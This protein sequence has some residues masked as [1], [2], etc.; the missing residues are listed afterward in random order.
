MQYYNVL[1]ANTQCVTG[2]IGHCEYYALN[3]AMSYCEI[4]SISDSKQ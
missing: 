1:A 4:Y 2:I 3:I